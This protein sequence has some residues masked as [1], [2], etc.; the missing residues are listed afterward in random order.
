MEGQPSIVAASQRPASA[1]RKAINKAAVRRAIA[2][3]G[4]DR[5]GSSRTGPYVVGCM[6]HAGYG[7]VRARIEMS[8]GAG[9]LKCTATTSPADKMPDLIR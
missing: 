2:R 9:G 5:K 1:A 3:C 6:V 4:I 7:S 8:V